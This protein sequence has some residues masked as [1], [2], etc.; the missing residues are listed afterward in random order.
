MIPEAIFEIPKPKPHDVL[1]VGFDNLPEGI[2][3]SKYLTGNDL[4]QIAS[5]EKVPEEKELFEMGPVP[6]IK[7][8]ID[9]YGHDFAAFEK[10]MHLLAKQ[11]VEQGN[12]W[13]AFKILMVVEYTR[14]GL[15]Q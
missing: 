11:E 10:E 6:E 1:S 3:H 14:E 12:P 5:C 13:F 7:M 9:K 15:K 8:I 4:A 2:S